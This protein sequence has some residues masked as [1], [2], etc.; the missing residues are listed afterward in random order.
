MTSA[1]RLHSNAKRYAASSAKSQCAVYKTRTVVTQ[2]RI[3]SYIVLE[4]Y[5][6]VSEKG[7]CAPRAPALPL[8]SRPFFYSPRFPP[9]AT[10]QTYFKMEGTLPNMTPASLPTLASPIGARPRR[11][12]ASLFL[13]GVLT[14]FACCPT[15]LAVDM[16]RR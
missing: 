14:M 6:L 7:G 3:E 16:N 15:W 2:L 11:G 4:L 13:Y 12:C 10:L 1:R 8:A 5:Q 9:F